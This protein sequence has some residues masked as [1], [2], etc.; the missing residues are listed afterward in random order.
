MMV[1]CANLRHYLKN[2]AADLRSN[3]AAIQKCFVAAL[4]VMRQL[5]DSV[6]RMPADNETRQKSLSVDLHG[7]VVGIPALASKSHKP[8]DQ[9]SQEIT[10]IELVAGARY[11]F[12]QATYVTS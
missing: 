2:L 6:L 7:H 11:R 5:I 3:D 12:K 8:L 4:A 10:S 1:P 9:N